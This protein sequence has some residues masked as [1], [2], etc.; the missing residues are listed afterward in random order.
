MGEKGDKLSNEAGLSLQ[1]LIE[2]LSGIEGISS[3]KMFG[4]YGIFCNDKMFGMVDPK[5]N[6]FF[7]A[8]AATK[9]KF[10]DIGSLKHSRMPY[11]S[12]P[13]NVQNNFELL[14]EWTESSIS[15][16]K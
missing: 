1:L 2:K 8:D 5:G 7:K 6:I 3:K 15:T 12:L 11:Y 10:E 16:T 14:L 4:G 13:D 9:G